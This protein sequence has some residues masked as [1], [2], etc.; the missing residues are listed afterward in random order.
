MSCL[1]LAC[2]TTTVAKQDPTPFV[3]DNEFRSWFAYY[4]K[5]PH[6]ERITAALSFMKRHGYLNENSKRY[7]D[8]PV[9]ASIFLGQ[10]FAANDQSLSRWS[11]SWQNL[12]PNEWY[13][14]L[15]SLRMADRPQA[16]RLLNDN[17]N[18]VDRDHQQRLISLRKT[19]IHTLDPLTAEVVT[20]R[21]IS[22][23]WSGFNAT[24]D[25]RYAQRVVDTIHLFGADDPSAQE[26]GET[27][28]MSLAT[29]VIQ[30]EAVSRLCLEQ[31]QKHED[32]R[33]RLLLEAMLAAIV[34]AAEKRGRDSISH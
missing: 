22:L 21:Q 18:K 24:G 29:H 25:L 6:P 16:M 9:I 8:I 33:T 11:E 10:I 32:P 34:N 23:L 31:R 2:V 17:L 26:I 4:Y 20:S 28:L 14:I 5:D 15:V 12:G 30:H 3:T 13:V 1:L 19:D 7:G 27:A